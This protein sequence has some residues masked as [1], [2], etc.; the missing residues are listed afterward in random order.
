M[1]KHITVCVYTHIQTYT[2]K[3]YIVIYIKI[4]ASIAKVQNSDAGRMKYS[5]STHTGY[6]A[7][8]NPRICLFYFLNYKKCSGEPFYN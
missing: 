1:S 4:I 2:P 5:F 8:L 6:K 7:M 3:T